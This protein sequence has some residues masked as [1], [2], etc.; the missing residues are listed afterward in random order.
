[1][2]ASAAAGLAAIGMDSRAADL[3]AVKGGRG[4][5]AAIGR[6]VAVSLRVR[7]RAGSWSKA[8]LQPRRR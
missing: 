1:M 3:M 7:V 6:P 4:I 8:I 2:A 5:N